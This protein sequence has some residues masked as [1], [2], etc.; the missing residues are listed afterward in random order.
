MRRK[1]ILLT[2]LGVLALA[3]CEEKDPVLAGERLNVRD[4]LETRAGADEAPQAVSRAFSKMRKAIAQ[5][6]RSLHERNQTN[7]LRGLWRRARRLQ[8]R[9][10]QYSP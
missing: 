8:I 1:A 2:T 9:K 4:V 7:V 6:R 10:T 3:G 5:L